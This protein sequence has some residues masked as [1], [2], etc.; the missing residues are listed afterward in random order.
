MKHSKHD[1]FFSRLLLMLEKLSNEKSATL[2]ELAEEYGV[3]ERTIRRDI[4]KLHFFPIEVKNSVVMMDEDFDI[5]GSRFVNEELIITELAFSAIH[6]IDEEL[7]K[8][9]HSV[10]AKASH[11]TFFTPYHIKAELYEEIDMDSDLLNKIED[12]ITKRNVSK[13]KSNDVVSIVHPYK[14][15]SFDGIWYLLARD[16]A[17]EKIKTYLISGIQ[18]F[19]ATTNLMPEMVK[20]VSKL[21]E[22]VHTAWFEDGNSFEVKVKVK[23]QI[24]NYF[25]LKK[26]LVSQEII[27]ENKDGSIIVTF[28]VSTDEDVDNLIKSWLPHIEVIKPERFRKKLV[29]ELEEYVK[30][31][32][33]L[34]N[35]V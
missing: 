33:E 16:T 12:A 8:R 32:K 11:P 29:L 1:V 18:E 15:V 26:H 4:E 24:A 23:A 28:R 14:V 25:K 34:H 7:D 10:R 3:D 2:K 6:G 13:V 30:N 35:L 22:N 20:D 31:L 19:R 27:K 21:L 5:K 17:D 9:M